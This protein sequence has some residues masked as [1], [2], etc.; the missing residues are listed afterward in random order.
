MTDDESS[1]L[2]TNLRL[3]IEWKLF[4][5]F[6]VSL[7]IFRNRRAS[8][9]LIDEKAIPSRFSSDLT[10]AIYDSKLRA[11]NADPGS[12]KARHLTTVFTNYLQR[13]GYLIAFANYLLEKSAAALENEAEDD[14]DGRSGVS[15]SLSLSS[16][17][18]G[19]GIQQQGGNGEN[20]K[21][22]PSFLTWLKPRREITN[23]LTTRKLV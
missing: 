1:S 5:T 22:F 3:S 23:L 2:F 19:A 9:I 18:V 14:D 15:T 20:E 8:R 6:E 17:N 21:K 12:A 4:K 11:S 10:G 16:A 7:M 13:Y